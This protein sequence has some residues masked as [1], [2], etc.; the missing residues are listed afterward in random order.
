MD[1]LI[2]RRP[3]IYM[4]RN[5]NYYKL[6]LDIRIIH[7]VFVFVDIDRAKNL[8]KNILWFREK[9]QIVSGEKV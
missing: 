3:S 6:Y 7:W 9:G 8:L 1:T 4:K 5:S 2:L